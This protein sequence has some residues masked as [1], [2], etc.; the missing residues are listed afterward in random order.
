MTRHPTTT[1]TSG[2]CRVD[3]AATRLGLGIV[4]TFTGTRGHARAFFEQADDHLRGILRQLRPLR[5]AEAGADERRAAG[6]TSGAASRSSPDL[7]SEI[8]SYLQAA[9]SLHEFIPVA[10]AV[11]TSVRGWVNHASYGDTVGLRRAV[12][13]DVVLS[14]APSE[15]ERRRLSEAARPGG[16]ARVA[17]GSA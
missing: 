15:A 12:L 3:S 10:R 5:P 14:R 2:S 7:D 9:K 16:D 1:S 4:G 13:K 6:D 8:A 11:A 17:Y